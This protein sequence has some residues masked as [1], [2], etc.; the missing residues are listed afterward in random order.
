MIIGL[1]GYARTG[2]DTVADILVETYGF[3]RIAFADKL[4]A[5]AYDLNPF[6]HGGGGGMRRL[7][8]EVN[9]FGWEKAKE[10]PEVR[11]ILQAL[12]QAVREN[13]GTQV[14]V[15]AALD[16]LAD[17]QPAVITDVRYPNEAGAVRARGGIVVRVL[18]LGVTAVNDHVSESAM[19]DPALW[20]Y[21]L[22][23]DGSLDHL[24]TR[25]ED[26]A[27]FLDARQRALA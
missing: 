22:H 4:K 7:Q 9:D 11:R 3:R 18:R 25:V 20:D 21:V 23:N 24:R 19:D 1:S 12:G 15:D 17:D 26:L 2:K 13:V 14:W 27:S 5:V 16:A 10:R 8:A 6:I